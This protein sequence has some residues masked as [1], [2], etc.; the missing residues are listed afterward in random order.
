MDGICIWRKKVL[1]AGFETVRY[2]SLYVSS[3]PTGQIGF[4]MCKKNGEGKEISEE[5]IRI[6][7]SKIEEAGMETKYYHPG[8]QKR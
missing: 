5:E 8:L 6:R 1:Q 2:G 7:F 4:L 3:Y